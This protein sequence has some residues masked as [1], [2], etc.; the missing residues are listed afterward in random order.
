[1]TVISLKGLRVVLGEPRLVAED[2]GHVW[3]PRIDR[4]ADG[5]LIEIHSVQPDAEDITVMGSGICLSHDNG[6]TW[7]DSYQ[8]AY[9][10]GIKVAT[11]REVVGLYPR[12][13][14]DPPG[15]LRRVAAHYLVF[16]QSGRRHV[17]ES[18]AA[19]VDGFPRDLQLSP[20][21]GK[22]GRVWPPLIALHNK[23]SIALG[24]DTL[25]TAYLKYDDDKLY[26]TVALLSPDQGR[27]WRYLAQIAGPDAFAG[28]SE[29]PCEADLT[30]LANGDIMCVMRNGS[31]RAWPVCRSYSSDGGKTWSKPDRLP[32]WSVDPTLCRLHNDVVALATGRPGI[33]LWAATDVRATDWQPI[34][35][36][37]HHNAVAGTSW[38]I[39]VTSGAEGDLVRTTCYT[40]MVQIAPNQFVLVYDR[41]PFGGQGVPA[42]ST[43][44]SHIFALPIS[45]ERT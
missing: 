44:R 39:P 31:G 20:N 16:D 34:D 41:I 37:A 14:A 23:H 22:R 33:Y 1:M 28:M 8:V 17:T 9:G 27:N 12:P 11:E 13:Y 40:D 15:Q 45:I 38:Q 43:E 5:T 24:N 3:F 29:G 6:Q 19:H 36:L 21:L 4:Y 2:I 7:G 10:A 35:V 26:T 18:W 30:Q 32:A 25:A 42:D